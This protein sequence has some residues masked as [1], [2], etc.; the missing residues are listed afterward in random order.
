MIFH[1]LTLFLTFCLIIQPERLHYIF[2][3][4]LRR[5]TFLNFFSIFHFEMIKE[6]LRFLGLKLVVGT[7]YKA[8]IIQLSF[9]LNAIILVIG[10]WPITLHLA[11]SHS[12]QRGRQD[13]SMKVTIERYLTINDSVLEWFYEVKKF[14]KLICSLAGKSYY[15]QSVPYRLLQK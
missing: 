7:Q 10:H 15:I 2:Y 14:P 4:E 11:W 1:E 3:F 6:I 8:N 13:H 12:L 5:H 9:N